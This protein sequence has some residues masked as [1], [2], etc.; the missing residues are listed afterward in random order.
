MPLRVRLFVSYA[1]VILLALVLAGAAS[2]GLRWRAQRQATL[3]RLVVA[4]PQLMLDV[5]RLR[6]EGA[7]QEQ[8]TAVLREEARQRGVRVLLVDRSG[9]VIVDTG[10]T[11]RG[12]RLEVPPESGRRGGPPG[13]RVWEGRGPE[14]GG[15]VFLTVRGPLDRVP[16]AGPLRGGPLPELSDRLVLAVPRQ[17]VARA[18]LGLLP[19]LVWAGLIALALSAIV[20]VLL[21]RSIARPLQALTRASEEMARGNY[22]QQIPLRRRDEVGRLASAFNEMARQVGRSHVQMRAL[23]ANVS[24][25]LKTPL[26]SILG[27]AQALRDGAVTGPEQTA[28][29]GAIIHEE[30][31]RMQALVEDLLYLSEIEAGEVVLTREPVDLGA[32]AA[33]AARRFEPALRER[34]MELTVDVPVGGAHGRAPL[35]IVGD[36]ARLERVLDNLLDNARKYTP[37]GGRV[38][39]HGRVEPGA[40]PAVHLGVFNSGS[41]IP[42]QDLPRVFDRFYRRDRARARAGGSGLGLAIAKELVELHGGSLTAASDAAGT[43]FTVVLPH[44]VSAGGEPEPAPA[45]P[46]SPAAGAPEARTA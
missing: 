38:D 2:I 19:G 7:S 44:A 30:A 42:P 33:R 31:E 24:H 27:F 46:A 18:W 4:A 3:D 28:E 26:T 23:V 5:F 10:D 45:A 12:R 34:G 13:Y 25:D 16:G 41:H 11:L 43:T 17:T 29:T 22:D 40:R 14:Q 35:Q 21:A 36:S 37:D 32:L 39:V 1:A 8:V 6:R 9:T 15:L 20:A